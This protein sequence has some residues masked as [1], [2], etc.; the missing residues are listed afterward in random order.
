MMEAPPD[1]KRRRITAA[2]ASPQGMI[3]LIDLPTGILTHA[4]S[5]LAG[6][7]RALFAITL[8]TNSPSAIVDN[9]WDTL[10]FGEIE[11]RVAAKL[12][13]DGI[14]K[15]LLCIDAVNNV[16]RLKLTN[17]TKITGAGLEPLRGSTTIEQ[18]DLSLVGNRQS[19]VITPRPSISCDHVLPI[20][21]SILE[22]TQ[23]FQFPVKWRKR[24][25]VDSEFDAFLRR[26]N[27]TWRS[28]GTKNCLKCE[29]ELPP[30]DME[31]FGSRAEGQFGV[32]RHTCCACLKHYC[33]SCMS[34]DDLRMINSCDVCDRNF[35]MECSAIEFCVGCSNDCCSTCRSFVACGSGCGNKLCD[36]C[37]YD[38]IQCNACD[39]PFC[40][41]C[42]FDG[43]V[44][45]RDCPGHYC[46]NCISNWGGECQC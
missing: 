12:T 31:W 13:D 44:Y 5:F 25:R 29:E 17:C 8:D 40:S 23:Y 41:D 11:K 32:Q 33:D 16:K 42:N 27:Q 24:S 2:G 9:Q 19:P 20:L 37:N 3:R 6:P 1:V 43:L 10:D 7:S 21:D 15:I 26:C 28:R 36:E 45:C 30:I 22:S 4:A 34:D 18:I 39:E 46:H 38:E 35:C 14:E